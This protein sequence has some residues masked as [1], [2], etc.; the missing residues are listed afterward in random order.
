MVRISVT[1]WYA[2]IYFSNFLIA[3]PALVWN[4]SANNFSLSYFQDYHIAFQLAKLAELMSTCGEYRTTSTQRIIDLSIMMN[5]SPIF[6]RFLQFMMKRK[7][8]TSTCR[9]IYWI[10]KMFLITPP[11]KKYSALRQ[12][13]MLQL[14]VQ[15]CLLTKIGMPIQTT[16]QSCEKP[17]NP[18]DWWT[19][20]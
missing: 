6:I 20:F 19:L 15:S 2:E 18:K 14:A 9:P 16:I 5:S 4:M 11:R 1:L 8:N 10:P 12:Y 13:L 3:A 7:R 17:S